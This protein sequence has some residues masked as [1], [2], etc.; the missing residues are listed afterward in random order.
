MSK[1]IKMFVGIIL[2]M[3]S[4]ASLVIA[5]LKI[6]EVISSEVASEAFSKTAYTFGAVFVVSLVILLVA[7]F[8]EERK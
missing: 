3:F 6:W 5:V 7:S 4:V 8:L 1:K 2:V